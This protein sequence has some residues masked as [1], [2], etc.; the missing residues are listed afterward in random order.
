MKAVECSVRADLL[1]EK[2]VDTQLGPK[3]KK[4]LLEQAQTTGDA[5]TQLQDQLNKKYVPPS[6]KQKCRLDDLL[7]FIFYFYQNHPDS[8]RPTVSVLCFT[9]SCKSTHFI[10]S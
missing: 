1:L 2:A 6:P 8:Q 7:F 4:V 5:V 9:I 3:T 10:S